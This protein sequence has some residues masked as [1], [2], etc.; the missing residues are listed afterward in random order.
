[1]AW[2]E[3]Q[4]DVSKELLTDTNQ[5]LHCPNNTRERRHT[6][7]SGHIAANTPLLTSCCA[8][9]GFVCVHACGT[10]PRLCFCMSLCLCRRMAVWVYVWVK[11]ERQRRTG[12]EL[13]SKGYKRG[14]KKKKRRSAFCPEGFKSLE[15]EDVW[16]EGQNWGRRTG[17]ER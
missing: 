16:E 13:R 5:T 10:V 4:F 15:W 1:M 8:V 6:S 17:R 2:Y 9:A 7:A 3:S 14:E 12:G 11:V